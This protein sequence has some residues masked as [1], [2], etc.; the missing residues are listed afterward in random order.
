M[1]AF[2]PLPGSCY[3]APT[4]RRLRYLAAGARALGT[5]VGFFAGLAFLSFSSGCGPVEF[6]NQV[7]GKATGAVAAAKLAGAEQHAPYEYT[8]AV[9]YLHK[10]R[11]EAGHAEYQVAIRYGRRAEEL[12][13][14]A[15]ALSDERKAAGGT[16]PP[17]P[18]EPPVGA[19]DSP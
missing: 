11:E 8:A 19:G 3:G 13:V 16:P 9:E 10:A 17:P 4:L 18:V 2:D 1:A 5:A 12:A 6:L 7:S 15:R 14:R